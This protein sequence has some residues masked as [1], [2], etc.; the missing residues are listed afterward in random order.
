MS[1][2]IHA[3]A[4]VRF[5]TPLEESRAV[6]TKGTEQLLRLAFDCPNLKRFAHISTIFVAGRMEGEIREGACFLPEVGI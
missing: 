5:S 3:A 1:A 4:A 6:N 2:I